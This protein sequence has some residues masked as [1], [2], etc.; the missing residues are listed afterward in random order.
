MFVNRYIIRKKKLVSI[1]ISLLLL[2]IN[3]L[4]VTYY[5]NNAQTIGVGKSLRIV[6]GVSIILY[7]I[8]VY[9]WYYQ[10]KELLCPYIVFFTVMYLF[11]CG[12]CIGWFSGLDLGSKDMWPRN[13]HGINHSVL[14]N[15]VCYTIICINCFHIGALIM[16]NGTN[17]RNRKL[18]DSANVIS[19]FRSMGKILLIIAIP[20]FIATM[21]QDVLSVKMGGYGNYYESRMA[22]T[23]I[24]RIFSILS[25]YYQPCMLL[26]LIAYRDKK[27]YRRIILV[28]M[29]LD[30]A[31]SLY[32]GGRSGAVMTLLGLVLAYHYFIKKFTKPQLFIGGGV[33]YVILAFLNAIAS[34]RHIANRNLFTAIQAIP[35]EM[36]N[37]IGEM[38][39]ELGWN[40]TSICWTQLLVPA[41]FNFR[42]GMSYL[43]SLISWIPSSIFGG[44][45][46]ADTYG[47]L[48]N[49]L[50]KALG[51]GYGPGYTMVAEAYI[52]FGNYGFLVMIIEGMI[53]A[54][55]L[56]SVRRNY[57]ENN[58]FGATFQILIIMVL[59]KPIVRSSMTV[60]VRTGVL[61][62]LPLYLLILYKLKRRT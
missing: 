45:H 48:A 11:C 58:I 34:T 17:I 15:G 39:G 60:A 6:S 49:W 9:T 31:L 53:I 51:M 23:A 2:L 43:V 41:Y 44:T 52:N 46:P 59:M 7:L 35:Q 54:Y 16:E 28:M 57:V 40:I 55:V 21:A 19:C 10:T 18:W 8:C 4:I 36:G 26:L 24:F 25:N 32:I 33:G 38:I 13:D 30:V 61:V 56:S 12:E 62:L 20:A 3:L 47:A 29:F 5:H 50:Q 1:C 37:A 27:I 14:L 42:Y 22:R